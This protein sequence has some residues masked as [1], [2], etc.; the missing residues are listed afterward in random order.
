MTRILVAA[1]VL[2][3][4]SPLCLAQRR[5]VVCR[6]GTGAF[7]ATSSRGVGV[8][9]RAQK[10]GKLDLRS[11]EASLTWGK[12]RLSVASAASQIDLDVFEADVTGRGPAAAFQIKKSEE[13]CCAVYE[14]YALEKPPRL[15]RTI[16][17]GGFYRAADANLDGQ[18]E[19]LTNDMAA[20][21]GFDGL[22]AA[23]VAFPPACV[24]RFEGGRLL[25]ASAEFRSYFDHVIM[26]VQSKI[27]P[28]LLHAFK[29]SDG[30]LQ[31][32]DASAIAQPQDLRSVKIQILEIVWAYLYSGRD[33]QAWRS[34]A[35]M[36][37]SDDVE[38]IRAAITAARARGVHSQAD[39]SIN[40]IETPQNKRVRVYEAAEVTAP[41]AILFQLPGPSGSSRVPEGE[42]AL[43]LIIDAAGK[44]QAATQG[45]EDF[46]FLASGW[47]FVPALRNGRAVACHLRLV[48]S[49][50]R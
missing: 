9:V 26:A 11:C 32:R 21:E 25:D 33:Q 35:E 40:E 50:R 38:R 49:F 23:D 4:M 22:T 6:A 20:V 28:Q 30:K 8:E 10:V 7:S 48:I 45:K 34:L 24:L 13:Q 12:E 46:T 31:P 27:D 2:G 41:R 1:L 19:I 29:L 18:I 44:V 17:G 37:P 16:T 5:D 36:W 14:I 42:I 43:D 15:V 3:L 47:K 39:A